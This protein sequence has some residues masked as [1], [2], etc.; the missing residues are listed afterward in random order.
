MARNDSGWFE[1]A[2]VYAVC[3]ESIDS[4]AA[5]TL[6]RRLLAVC[7]AYVGAMEVDDTSPYHWRLYSYGLVPG[8]RVLNRAMHVFWEGPDEDS[9]V[10]YRFDLAVRCGFE[11]VEWES[12]NYRYS[13]FDVYHDFGHAKRVAIWKRRAGNLLAFIADEA[14]TKLSD[15]AP[16]IGDKLYAAMQQFEDAET[17]E[18]LANALLGCRRTY[19]YVVD[20]LFPAIPGGG[21]GGHKLDA[22][23]VRNRLLAFA[24][25]QQQS[26][27]NVS[28][29]ATSI[30]SWAKQ[31]ESFERLVNKGIHQKVCRA[32]ARRCLLKTILLLDDIASLRPGHFEMR[33]H[34][35]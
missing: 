1:Q 12:E 31:I 8:Y 7:P 26:A 10:Q 28:V 20:C 16:A 24:E 25:K 11:P 6:H 19:D 29:V 18:N 14:V 4:D 3:L 9:K 2:E 27:T 21:S 30:D 32:E 23:H 17:V 15:A 13:V 35:Q 5:E 22:E 33:G 34:F